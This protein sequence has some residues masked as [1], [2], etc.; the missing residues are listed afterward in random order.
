MLPKLCIPRMVFVWCIPFDTNRFDHISSR[1]AY[2]ASRR[3]ASDYSEHIGVIISGIYTQ[4][5][6]HVR[7]D[8]WLFTASASSV[9]MRRALACTSARPD[10]SRSARVWRAPLHHMLCSD[11][12]TTFAECDPTPSELNLSIRDECVP[13]CIRTHAE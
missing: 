8:L 5:R 11:S 3:T 12:R 4:W 6:C 1:G 13:L 2:G 9:M 10:F 7:T